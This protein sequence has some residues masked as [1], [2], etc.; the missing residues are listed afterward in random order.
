MKGKVC[1][2][3]GAS[4]GIGLVTARELAKK[5]ATVSMPVTWKEVEAGVAPNAFPIGDGTTLKRLAGDDPWKDFFEKAKAL[6]L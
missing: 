6:K 2:V 4:A 5:G 3:T 1:I